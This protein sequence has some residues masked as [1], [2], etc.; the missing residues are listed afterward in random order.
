MCLCLAAMKRG[1]GE[2]NR[3]ENRESDKEEI[4]KNEKWRKVKM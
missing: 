2:R 3:E 4:V 1:L